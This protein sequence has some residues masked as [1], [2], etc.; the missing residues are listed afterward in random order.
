MT[1]EISVVIPNWNGMSYLENCLN[2]LRDQ[3]FPSYEVIVVDNGST[4]GSV[5]F[6]RDHPLETR[7]IAFKENR[8]FARA[9]NEGIKSARGRYVLLLNN[10]VEADP[11]LLRHLHEAITASDDADFCACRM[12]NFGRR[13]LIDGIGDGFPRKGKAFRIGNGVKYGPPFHR[14]RRVFG[15]CAG[16]AFYPKTLFETVG[17]FDEDFF[18]YHEDADWNFRANFMGYRCFSIPEAVVYH[19]GSSTTG[20]LINEFTVFYNIRNMINVI[21][22]NMPTVLL[23]K[24]LPRILWGQVESF[25][26]YCVL[27]GYWRSYFTGLCDAMRLSPKMVKK[28]AEIQGKRA[29]SDFQLKQLFIA[30][31]RE[32]KGHIQSGQASEANGN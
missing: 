1:P 28:R 12:M 23:F 8:G 21:V 25:F 27:G 24:Y 15:A 3:D 10:D 5:E 31:E 22:K 7:V 18:A 16:A 32:G 20:G 11:R 19:I 17:L 30:S 4:D 26:R 2:S 29:I 6:I 14:R 9:V 13:E